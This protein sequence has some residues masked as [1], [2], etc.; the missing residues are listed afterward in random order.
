[1]NPLHILGNKLVHDSPGYSYA[2]KDRRYRKSELPAPR[3]SKDETSDK[4]TN[5]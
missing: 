1:M 4:R 3:V 2:W 5:V